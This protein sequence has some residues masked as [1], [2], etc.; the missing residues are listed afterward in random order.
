MKDE[1]QLSTNFEARFREAHRVLFQ[2]RVRPEDA[3]VEVDTESLP[4]VPAGGILRALERGG[5]SANKA[6]ETLHRKYY[7]ATARTL[8]RLLSLAGFPAALW[9][10]VFLLCRYPSPAGNAAP[11][12]GGDDTH[13][14]ASAMAG[15]GKR[16][17]TQEYAGAR[18]PRLD[19]PEA[20]TGQSQG[21]SARLPTA[22]AGPAAGKDPRRALRGRRRK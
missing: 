9:P 1:D 22:P 17:S 16:W 6:V 20:L 8:K 14:V 19:K 2:G 3:M 13:T 7:H 4:N 10:C 15:L 5:A 12:Q 11:G 21:W 18:V